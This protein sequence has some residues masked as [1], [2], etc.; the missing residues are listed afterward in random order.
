LNLKD[1]AHYGLFDASGNNLE[2]ALRQAE[3]LVTFAAEVLRR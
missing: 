1:R 2:A 3:T